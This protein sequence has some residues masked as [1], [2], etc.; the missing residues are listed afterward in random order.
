MHLQWSARPC[1]ND[2]APLVAPA[3]ATRLV[4]RMAADAIPSR[5]TCQRSKKCPWQQSELNGCLIVWKMTGKSERSW[6]PMDGMMFYQSIWCFDLWIGHPQKIPCNEN[7]AEFP[8][9]TFRLSL[10]IDDLKYELKKRGHWADKK[11]EVG[12]P[13][14][15]SFFP[16]GGF[17]QCLF[18]FHF[19]SGRMTLE[20]KAR[21]QYV[22]LETDSVWFGVGMFLVMSNKLT[23]SHQSAHSS[24]IYYLHNWVNSYLLF[25]QKLDSHFVDLCHMQKDSFMIY[26]GF[27][28]CSG[29]ASHLIA[30]PLP[31]MDSLFCFS[32]EDLLQR[33]AASESS[34]PSWWHLSR[35]R[36]PGRR[37]SMGY[38]M[39]YGLGNSIGKSVVANQNLRWFQGLSRTA[40]VLLMLKCFWDI[41][42]DDHITP[43]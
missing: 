2:F 16:V 24:I 22:K 11:V 20:T 36:H 13:Q 19:P 26:N 8:S 4:T 28:L 40:Q 9:A 6:K 35:D 21:A 43:S 1:R 37:S 15:S 17:N 34:N 10:G 38:T 25:Y 39:I 30:E 31:G 5:T 42:A 27:L 3:V 14:V 23:I 33:L 41:I 29:T 18:Y 32:Q 12:K 7:L